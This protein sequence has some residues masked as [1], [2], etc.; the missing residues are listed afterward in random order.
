MRRK[1]GESRAKVIYAG[2]GSANG[3]E[4]NNEPEIRKTR[5]RNETVREIQRLEPGSLVQLDCMGINECGGGER[6]TT[7][8]LI[9]Q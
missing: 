8:N 2:D 5:T 7:I 9:L 4:K 3:S 6:E 1:I